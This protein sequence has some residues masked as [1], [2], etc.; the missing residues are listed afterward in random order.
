MMEIFRHPWRF[1]AEAP[2]VAALPPEGPPEV[3][4]AGRSN[5]GKSSLINALVRQSRPRAHLQHAGPHAGAHLLRARSPEPAGRAAA[6]ALVDMPGYGYAKAPKALVARWTKL[7]HAYLAG[8]ADAEAR[9]PA[10]RFAPRH[11]AGR[12]R[13]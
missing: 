8:R 13:R 9:V 4:F 12:R 1:V 3:A 10:D 2:D 5:V 6:I 7:I 11:E